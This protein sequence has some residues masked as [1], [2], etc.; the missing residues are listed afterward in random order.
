MT[1]TPGQWKVTTFDTKGQPYT[2]T[3]PPG[4]YYHVLAQD[5][6]PPARWNSLMEFSH[7]KA[8]ADLM[9]AA[10]ALLAAVKNYLKHFDGPER[11]Q[12]VKQWLDTEG[13]PAMRQAIALAETQL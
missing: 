2:V 5:T 12:W 8:D 3:F 1:H 13:I 4:V 7:N 11:S 10:P 9:A 6:T